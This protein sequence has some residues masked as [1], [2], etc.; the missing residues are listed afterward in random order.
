MNIKKI[1]NTAKDVA[2]TVLVTTVFTMLKTTVM[3]AIKSRI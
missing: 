3:T 1:A 2:I